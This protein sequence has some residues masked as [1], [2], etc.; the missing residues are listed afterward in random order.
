M[1]EAPL[2][3]GGS[4]TMPNPEWVGHARHSL[5][6]VTSSNTKVYDPPIRLLEVTG[7][8]NLVVTLDLDDDSNTASKTTIAISGA[9]EISNRAIRKIWTDTTCSLG[10]AYT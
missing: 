9:T 1:A 2:R 7:A 4:T 8:G 10:N 5:G 3:T 6:V